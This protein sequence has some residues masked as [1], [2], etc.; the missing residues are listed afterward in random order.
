MEEAA[1]RPVHSSRRDLPAWR[2]LERHAEQMHGV[3]LRELFDRD[4]DRARDLAVEACGVYVDLAK[5]RVTRETLLLLLALAEQCGLR[6][7]IAAMFAGEEINVSEHRAVLHVALR[8]PRGATITVDG[9]N[10]V[11]KVHEVLEKMAAF[12]DQVRGGQ[13]TGHTGKPIRAVINIGIGGSDLGPRMAYQALRPFSD[14]A[15]RVEFVSNI[16]GAEFV[17]ATRDLDPAETLFVVSSK[18]WHTLE[19]LTNAR[20][21]REW[22]LSAF[23][24]DTSAVAR[25]FVAVSTNADGVREFGIDPRNMFPFWDWVGGRYSFDAAVGL[26]LMVAVGPEHF[27]A[28]LAGFHDVDEHF[29]NTPL[30]RN[31]PV[32]MGLLAVWYNDFLGAQTQA[33]LPYSHYL[34]HLPAYLQQLEMESNGK[35][36][37]LSGQRVDYQTGQIIWGQPG[38]NGQHAFY[39]LLHQGTK[40]V[41]GEFI[42]IVAPMSP[43][44]HHHDLLLANVFAQTEALAFGRSEQELRQSASGSAEEQIPHRVCEGNRPTTTLLLDRLTPRSLGTLIALYEHKVF[45]EGVIWDIDSFDQWGVELGKI[46]ADTVSDE[47][48]AE[49]APTLRHDSSTNELIRRYRKLRGRDI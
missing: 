38:T 21:A 5:N 18:S 27:T 24:G 31:I 29:R 6:E 23:D 32:L 26:S 34:A 11:P 41:P 30:E 43:L 35:H 15:L 16:D 19:T 48:T 49:Q 14:R 45:T 3:T 20:T 13:W 28:M 10:V 9:E 36:V 17:E 7:R 42:G 46:L 40:L 8:A 22:T 25:H 12:A 47:L 2:A 37:T 4:P 1:R 44:H 33:V 39:Q